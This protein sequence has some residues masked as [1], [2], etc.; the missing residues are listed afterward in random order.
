MTVS[1]ATSSMMGSMGAG[2]VDPSSQSQAVPTQVSAPAAAAGDRALEYADL[3]D[4]TL[5]RNLKRITLSTEISDK[6]LALFAKFKLST[7]FWLEHNLE[8]IVL[9]SKD[10][11]EFVA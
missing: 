4:D 6:D 8:Q 5:K 7:L 11:P 10:K 2:F 9:T 1:N 3:T